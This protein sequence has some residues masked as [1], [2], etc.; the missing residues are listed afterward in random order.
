MARDARDAGCHLGPPTPHS[1][2][3]SSA[4]SA[5]RPSSAHAP[6][7][8]HG[9]GDGETAKLL[10][11]KRQARPNFRLHTIHRCMV[12]PMHQGGRR[13]GWVVRGQVSGGGAPTLPSA[14]VKSGWGRELDP[15]AAVAIWREERGTPNL[16][17]RDG[18]EG[19]GREEVKGWGFETGRRRPGRREVRRWRRRLVRSAALHGWPVEKRGKRAQMQE[20][21]QMVKGWYGIPFEWVSVS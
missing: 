7:H 10:I 14:A 21:Q 2:P 12:Y 11:K 16:C 15:D 4:T 19:K 6:A 1:T 20:A 18:S 8:V 13:D 5:T 3:L 17:G 9:D